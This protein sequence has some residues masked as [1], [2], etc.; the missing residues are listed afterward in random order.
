[1]C[2]HRPPFD[3]C[4]CYFSDIFFFV[5]VSNIV[6]QNKW[7]DLCARVCDENCSCDGW[8]NRKSRK[9]LYVERFAVYGFEI[10][11]HVEI[12]GWL[13]VFPAASSIASINNDLRIIYY[14]IGWKT[15]TGLFDINIDILH[16]ESQSTKVSVFHLS[17][18]YAV[19][20]RVCVCTHAHGTFD[21]Q[22]D[23]VA[24]WIPI[25]NFE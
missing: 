7:T 19:C 11:I 4:N 21:L 24:F 5:L 23:F 2:R 17:I 10:E 22:Y 13:W 16:D 15:P 20:V 3:S 12:P 6:Q 1:M 14:V 25:L 18:S 9:L 8:S